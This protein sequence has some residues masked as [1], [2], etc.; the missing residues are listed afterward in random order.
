MLSSKAQA[1]G[2]LFDVSQF[3]PELKICFERAQRLTIKAL[4]EELILKNENVILWIETDTEHVNFVRSTIQKFASLFFI[5][6]AVSE[7]EDKVT[8]RIAS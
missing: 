5:R 3:F 6:K 8:Y 1:K 2:K 4:Y 7:Q